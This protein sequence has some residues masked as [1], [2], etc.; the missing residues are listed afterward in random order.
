M[1]I[2]THHEEER[3]QRMRKRESEKNL[4]RRSTYWDVS[5]SNLFGGK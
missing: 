2:N 5:F 1:Q 4:P 3:M